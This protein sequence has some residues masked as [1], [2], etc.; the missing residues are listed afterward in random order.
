MFYAFNYVEADKTLKMYCRY[1]VCLNIN[2]F[3][4]SL[5]TKVLHKTASSIKL[6][7]FNFRD[8]S[9]KLMN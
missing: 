9:Q 7:F 3:L 4:L 2:A 5:Y 1:H 8:H 6:F